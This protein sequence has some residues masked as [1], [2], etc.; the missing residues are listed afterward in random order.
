MSVEESLEKLAARWTA[1]ALDLR[2]GAR[3]PATDA[4]TGILLEALL[5]VRSR[6]DRVEEILANAL[7]LRSMA[8]RKHTAI[9][10]A[11]E[12]A[13]DAAAVRG[14]SAG[15][16]DEYSSA[17]ERAA[18]ANLEVLDL[19]R[20]ERVADSQFRRCDEAVELVRLRLRGLQ[21]V[22]QDILAVVRIRQFESTLER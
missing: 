16:R 20:L 22:R 12:D 8:A 21:E 14:R 1:E 10:S 3:L 13:W 2:M 18:A 15:V 17:K 4:S 5:D 6:L 11:V 9:R 19:R 7:G